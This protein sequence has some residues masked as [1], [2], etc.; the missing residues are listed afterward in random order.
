MDP[1]HT[2]A[3]IMALTSSAVPSYL[4][5]KL[6][7]VTSLVDAV[8]PVSSFSSSII[9]S[10]TPWKSKAPPVAEGVDPVEVGFEERVQ[11][12]ILKKAYEEDMTGLGQEALF[13]MRRGGEWGNWGDYDRLVDMVTSQA[14]AA[15]GARLK[16]RIYFAESDIMIGTGKGP[17]WFDSCWK[18]RGAEQIDYRSSRVPYADHDYILNLRFGVVEEIFREISGLAGG[19]A[20][21]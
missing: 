11:K 16:L 7:T 18:S 5:G 6:Q 13:L 2:G 14:E 8:A 21:E 9:K 17:A 1:S 4:M 15:E 3:P 10:L 19:L 20:P 12:L